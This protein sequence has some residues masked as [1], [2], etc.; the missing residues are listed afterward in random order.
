MTKEPTI[1][2]TRLVKI[3]IIL[4]KRCPLMGKYFSLSLFSFLQNYIPNNQ[5]EVSE[6]LTALSYEVSVQ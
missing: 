6:R 1:Y 5:S 4:E 3:I 2:G